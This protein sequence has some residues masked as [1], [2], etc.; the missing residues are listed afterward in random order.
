ME[1]AESCEEKSGRHEQT[2]AQ[3]FQKV[4]VSAPVLPRASRSS[5]NVFTAP[6][7]RNRKA[8]GAKT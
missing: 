7:I 2:A 4:L 5:V 3:R 8:L 6:D 1:I